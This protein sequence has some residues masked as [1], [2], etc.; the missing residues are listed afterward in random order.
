MTVPI[1]DISP[2][3]NVMAH[4]EEVL[5][6]VASEWDLAMMHVGFAIIVGYGVDPHIIS[7]LRDVAMRCVSL[8]RMEELR[9]CIIMVRTVIL[10]VA[11][12]A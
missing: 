9:N 1:I 8:S 3:V 4:D 11:I 12:L 5:Q 2:F 6:H 7:D 10:L